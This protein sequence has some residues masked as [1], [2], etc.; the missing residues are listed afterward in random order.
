ME[1]GQRIKDCRA[2]AGMTQEELAEKLYVSR[3]TISS[4]E[5]NKSY[6]DAGDIAIPEIQRPFVW[7]AIRSSMMRTTAGRI[8]SSP[9]P[10]IGAGTY[11]ISTSVPTTNCSRISKCPLK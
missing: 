6:I 8:G 7:N 4:W 9:L 5:N 11:T 3:Q 1:L 10:G 2:R